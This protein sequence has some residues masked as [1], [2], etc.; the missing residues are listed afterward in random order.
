[1]KTSLA[2]AAVVAATRIAK[3]GFRTTFPVAIAHEV[4][5]AHIGLFDT[6]LDDSTPKAR[7]KFN[8]AVDLA[9]DLVRFGQA[10]QGGNK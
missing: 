1:M 6:D 9:A 7:Q 2:R 10:V 4:K 3:D 8:D 5:E